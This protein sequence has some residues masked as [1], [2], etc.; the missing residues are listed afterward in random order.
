VGT[1]GPLLAVFLLVGAVGAQETTSEVEPG[2]EPMPLLP[3]KPVLH[4]LSPE[5]L[6]WDRQE[7]VLKWSYITLSAVDAYQTSQA[8]GDVREANFL[9]SSWAGDHPSTASIVAFKSVATYGILRG[10]GKIQS[11]RKR[12]VALW[13]L[14]SLQLAIAIRN[15]KVSGGI[16]FGP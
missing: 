14:N 7:K 12:K 10:V 13:L 9:L 4:L 6:P 16:V 1:I 2:I 8:P 3:D 15:E 11:R 5:K